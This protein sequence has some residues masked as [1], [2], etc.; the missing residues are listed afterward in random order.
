MCMGFAVDLDMR[1]RHTAKSRQQHLRR[2][3][4]RLPSW[5][6]WIDA[7]E[8]RTCLLQITPH[9]ELYQHQHTQSDA[10]QG[11]AARQS[12]V[13]TAKTAASATT[14]A[15]STVRSLARPGTRCDTQ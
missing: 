3:L 1:Q 13:R 8:C 7:F 11:R 6:P 4:R 10:Q 14:S 2:R 5:L 9:D 15:L 12:D